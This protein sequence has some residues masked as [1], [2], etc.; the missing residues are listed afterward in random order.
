[1][2]PSPAGRLGHR[3]HGCCRRPPPLGTRWGRV[4]GSSGPETYHLPTPACWTRQLLMARPAE[5]RARR[6]GRGHRQGP[7]PRSSPHPLLSLT[8]NGWCCAG[9]RWAACC[10]ATTALRSRPAGAWRSGH[11]DRPNAART[12][13]SRPSTISLGRSKPS[14]CPSLP[15]PV[16]VNP[17]IC[18]PPAPPLQLT[19]PNS[20]AQNA[21]S[22]LIVQP[23][24]LA[25]RPEHIPLRADWPAGGQQSGGRGTNWPRCATCFSGRSSYHRGGAILASRSTHR[26]GAPPTA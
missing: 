16:A 1:V 25:W 9:L 17:A 2:P 12:G 11:A 26:P 14:D 6:G 22:E 7:R 4:C 21:G 3:R 5:L 18:P 20:G 24:W 10:R 19:H 13:P 23:T 15:T 8:R